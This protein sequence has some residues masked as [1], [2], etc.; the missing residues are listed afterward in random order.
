MKKIISTTLMLAALDAAAALSTT[1]TLKLYDNS[2]FDATAPSTQYFGEVHIPE[3]LAYFLL[4]NSGGKGFDFSLMTYHETQTDV[5]YHINA[6]Y[7]GI[8]QL[9][10]VGINKASFAE[11]AEGY[12]AIL[13]DGGHFKGSWFVLG[14][15]RYDLSKYTYKAK[16]SDGSLRTVSS[17]FNNV[18]RS[19][20]TY[21]ML[22]SGCMPEQDIPTLKSSDGKLFPIILTDGYRDR[23]DST[24]MGIASSLA[25][26]VYVASRYGSAME[27]GTDKLTVTLGGGF[28]DNASTLNVPACYSVTLTYANS[29]RLDLF[30]RTFGPGKHVLSN[31]G[32]NGNI[33]TAD[34]VRI[35]GCKQPVRA[36]P[37]SM[38]YAQGSCI[39]PN[40]GSPTPSNNTWAIVHSGCATEQRLSFSFTAGGSLRQKSSGMCLHPYGGS[41]TPPVNTP[42][43]FY[44]GC[45]EPRLAFQW[46]STGNL[47]HV[48]SGLCVVPAGNYPWYVT[49]PNATLLVLGTCPGTVWGSPINGTLPYDLSKWGTLLY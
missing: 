45:D 17:S 4:N 33:I 36:A 24:E 35:A 6:K 28:S 18:T 27:V 48:T 41:P 32:I 22:G 44:T 19:V 42:L 2:V 11:V 43:V 34:P 39:H 12:C 46:T 8:D 1:P 10:P 14:P 20:A 21:K 5:Y 25:G 15:G 49:P 16:N 31:Y 26:S 29:S 38:M 47:R 9:A 13:S 37:I 23:A 7:G 40:G 30:D 3:K